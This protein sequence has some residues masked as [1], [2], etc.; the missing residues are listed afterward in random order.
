MRKTILS[1]LLMTSAIGAFAQLKVLNDGRITVA[2]TATIPAARVTIGESENAHLFN[3]GVSAK[4]IPDD[5]DWNIGLYGTAYSPISTQGRACGI[6]GLAGN[7]ANGY[8]YGVMGLIGGTRNG[9]GV[10]GSTGSFNNVIWGRYAG[11]FNGA[12]RV[13]GN[14]TA[15]SFTTASDSGLLTNVSPLS[16]EGSSL[17]NIMNMDI[18]SFN[19]ADEK[20][21]ESQIRHYGIIAQELQEIYPDLVQ[22]GEDGYLA[23]NYVELVP[24]LVRSIQ[25]LK[26][27][28]EELQSQPQ[29]SAKKSLSTSADKEPI[30]SRNKLYQNTP[31][32]FKGQTTIRFSLAD[33]VNDAFICIF[34]MTGKILKKLP[35]S[36]GMKNI[37]ISSNELGEG[38]FLYSLVVNGKEIDTKK[39]I[40]TK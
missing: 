1:V 25:E 19:F 28:I 2:S 15:T 35:I 20:N 3:M 14:L 30:A 12:T 11:Y 24:V 5:S 4:I 31:N 7:G 40:I 16:E 27:Q 8:N 23:V 17:N 10:V 38:L 9:A 18:V 13:V 34:D 29:P 37:S 32:P 39:M 33:N 36:S 26:V 21:A 22:K 6:F